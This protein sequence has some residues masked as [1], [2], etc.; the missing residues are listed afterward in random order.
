MRNKHSLTSGYLGLIV[1]AGLCSGENRP[2][3]LSPS[4]KPEIQVLAI[5]EDR[6]EHVVL[7]ALDW[8]TTNQEE[9]GSWSIQKHG[10]QKGH[11]N[12]ATAMAILCYLGWGVNHKTPGEY[13]DVVEKALNWLVD[14]QDEDGNFMNRQH[15][16]M[17]DH[18]MA[19][20]A[21]AEAYGQTKDK[22]LKEPLEEAVTFIIEA[23]NQKH[24][25][26][27]YRPRSSRIDSS[28]SGWQL[29]ALSSARM[30]GIEMPDRP[31]ELAAKWLDTVGAGEHGGIYGYDRR[32]FKTHAMVAT[33]LSAQQL[34]GVSPDHPRMKESIQ[35]ISQN[36]PDAKQPNF[37][38]WYYANLSLFKPQ[39]PAWVKWNQQ[40]RPIWLDLQEK[41]GQNAGSWRPRGGNY[42]GDMGRVITTALATLS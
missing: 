4:R 34:L 7:K 13:Q 14:S 12:A 22:H 35:H 11:D 2:E 9:D 24:G 21:L 30:A 33:G 28:V 42:M 20:L 16:G 15:N 17:Y 40:M 23:Q 19:T 38:Y 25:A 3:T 8:F 39:G 18:G 41:D 1:L 29:S 36:L 32:V 10:G 37:Y 5:G 26:W 27:D 31:F 6:T